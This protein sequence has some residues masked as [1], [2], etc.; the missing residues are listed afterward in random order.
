MASSQSFVDIITENMRDA[1]VITS[2]KMFG[3]YAVYCNAKVLGFICDDNLFIKPTQEA[4]DFFQ[5]LVKDRHIQ[6]LK[7]IW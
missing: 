7:C 2:K 5:K 6:D 3:E 4:K 1:G